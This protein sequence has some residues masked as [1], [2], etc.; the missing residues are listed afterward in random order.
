MAIG[1]WLLMVTVGFTMTVEKPGWVRRTFGTLTWQ[2]VQTVC[3]TSQ[4][5]CAAVRHH[6]IY[7]EDMGDE[8]TSG[9]ET[10]D[11]G[12]GD[13]EDF[14]ACV[15][16]LCKAIG[17]EAT[18]QVFSP[19]GSFEGHVVAMGSWNGRLW[20]SSNGWY[21]TVKSTDDAKTVIAKEQGSG[22]RHREILSATPEEARSGA[23]A[24]SLKESKR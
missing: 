10:W 7:K 19:E 3:K 18:L 4:D 1:I 5:V 6:V 2:E 12:F 24:F 17:I 22:W 11:R 16:D 15:A 8:W 13:C 23:L 21:E 14:A 9:E 20:I